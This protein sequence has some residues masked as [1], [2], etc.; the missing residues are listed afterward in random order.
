MD[1][2]QIPNLDSWEDLTIQ[3]YQLAKFTFDFRTKWLTL[4]LRDF[5]TY[6]FQ[7]HDAMYVLQQL[8]EMVQPDDE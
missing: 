7:G 5:T 6:D 1:F 4:H 3:D 2:V 8:A